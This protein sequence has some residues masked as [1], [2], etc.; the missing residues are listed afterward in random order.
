MFAEVMTKS[1]LPC[2][3]RRS[4]PYTR[5]SCYVLVWDYTS[6]SSIHILNPALEDMREWKGKGRRD[7]TPSLLSSWVRHL[8]RRQ[9]CD[10]GELW[11]VDSRRDIATWRSRRRSDGQSARPQRRDIWSVPAA[12]AATTNC[13]RAPPEQHICD[14]SAAN[15]SNM[16]ISYAL[17][18][19]TARRIIP[20][21][22]TT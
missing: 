12:A 8:R 16:D 19:T 17:R 14:I 4:V 20:F 13:V 21:T 9:S 22:Y 15:R 11:L 6:C 3:L 1:R 10:P 5:M 18:I 7:N 2:L